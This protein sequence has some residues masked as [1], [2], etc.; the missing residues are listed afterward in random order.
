MSEQ[1]NTVL[2]E[3]NGNV[4]F[5]DIKGVLA[6]K[7]PRLA[8][9]MPGFLIRYLRKIV[10]EDSINNFISENKDVY[11]LDFVKATLTHFGVNLTIHGIENIQSEERIVIASNHPLGGLDGMAL[12]YSVGLE[13][14]NIAFPVNDILLNLKNLKS[15]FVP[16]NKHGANPRAAI[17]E[18]D[19]VMMS[20]KTVLFFPAGLVSRRK[21]G[22]IADLEW[23]KT[24][25]DKSKKSKRKIVPVYIDG[26]N[27]NFFYNLANF[28]KRFGIKT[29]IEM[30][31]LVNEMYKQ[32]N[33]QINLY[34][35]KPVSESDF[36]SGYDSTEKALFVKDLA[37]ALPK[38]NYSSKSLV[39][40]DFNQNRTEA[41]RS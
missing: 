32:Y 9:I 11:D 16:I 26:K 1:T 5:I 4:K 24:F 18:L 37:Y 31:Y 33:K 21:N 38:H 25:I 39:H 22:V 7:N 27:S 41:C 3:Q 23:K 35:G 34:F 2:P 12:I 15:M 28:R 20:D 14:K 13:R 8:K 40:T 6:R 17:R 19:E 10:H 36:P 30:F 29:N